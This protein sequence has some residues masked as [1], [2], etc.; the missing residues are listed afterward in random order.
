MANRFSVAANK[1]EK[2]NRFAQ[3]MQTG[4]VATNRFTGKKIASKPKERTTAYSSQDDIQVLKDIATSKGYKLKED[5]PSLF[6]RAMDIASRPLYA[7]AGAAKAL[8]KGE[9]VAQEAW[10]G[11]TGKEKETYS[12][13]L[14]SAGVKNKWIKGG[15]GLALDIAL[16]PTTYFGGKAI[17]LAA[18]GV[19]KVGGTGMRALE[20]VKPE[21]AVALT[22]GAKKLKEGVGGLFSVT[23]G[24]TEGVVKQ[25]FQQLNKLSLAKEE[26]INSYA[27][28]G[29]KLSPKQLEDMADTL[30]KHKRKL[31]EI[32]KGIEKTSIDDFNKQFP[33]KSPVKDISHAEKRFG[34]KD[35]FEKVFSEQAGKA[36][37]KYQKS[38]KMF[39]KKIE[40][41]KK[42]REVSLVKKQELLEFKAG[43]TIE[44]KTARLNERLESV[45]N[46][47]IKLFTGDLDDIKNS[48]KAQLIKD[49]GVKT[50]D[51]LPMPTDKEFDDIMN[52]VIN[53]IRDEL[54][55]DIQKLEQDVLGDIANMPG[56]K[57]EAGKQSKE[58]LA[59][60]LQGKIIKTQNEYNDLVF[61][62][63][64]KITEQINKMRE[65]L[66][67]RLS[68]RANE[69]TKKIVQKQNESF[70][71]QEIA[72]RMFGARD[73]AKS[74]LNKTKPEF[75]DPE[76]KRVY[77]SFLKPKIKEIG[78]K[79]GMPEETLLADYYP[80]ISRRRVAVKKDGT[81]AGVGVGNENYKKLDEGKMKIEEM[82]KDPIE[83]YT[84]RD[85]DVTR[86]EMNKVFLRQMVDDYGKKF[87]DPL[88]A[89]EEGYVM[90]KEKGQF[91]KELGYIK[92]NDAKFLNTITAPEYNAIDLFAKGVG[93]DKLTNTIKTALTAYFPA[94]HV[95]N[96]LSGLVQNYQVL[97][98]RAFAPA[99]IQTSLAILKGSEKT[100]L[101][102]PKWQGTAKELNRLFK[103]RFKGSSRYIGDIGD[104]I[105]ELGS[106]SFKMKKIS[107]ARAIGDFIESNQ[108]GMAISTALRK[109]H[110][111]DEAFDLAEKAG[112]DYNKM[113]G[114][115][116]SVMKRLIPFYAFA[117][118]NAKLQVG[119]MIHNPE[120]ILNQ[121]KVASALSNAIGEK[122]TEEDIKG[123]PDWALAGL[124]FKIKDGKY[125]SSLG[126][127]VEEFIGRLN[128]PIMSTLSSLN[129]M[130]K[131][132]LESKLGFDFFREQKIVDI[133]KV[134][135]ASGELLMKLKEEGKLPKIIDDAINIDRY[136]SPYDGK[137]K[138]TMSPKAL[139]ILRNIPT[140][141]LQN[142]LEKMFD[143]DLDKVNKFMAFFTGGK[144]Y[145]I[146]EETQAF[147]KERDLKTDMQAYL[148]DKGIGET[149]ENFYIKKEELAE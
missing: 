23:S 134:A 102:F 136:V 93:Y 121:V 19:N 4:T 17:T 16:D 33:S 132:P 54:E 114:F 12:D 29:T 106:N 40:N 8:V 141:R 68:L 112:F 104:Y 144:V 146:N 61:K 31:Q 46:D 18:K 22:E 2:A 72:N 28:L 140:A 118:N 145:D 81:G 47:E 99:N 42:K 87:D 36:I 103:E 37:D 58:A 94:F 96:M 49:V 65:S 85:F 128:N 14:E 66:A 43:E 73:S 101:K 79:T 53:P 78:K 67:E 77:E 122:V 90:L 147:F 142:T 109:G 38:I 97:G 83:A 113:T 26:I 15:V 110:T 20:K 75:S 21:S 10:K 7:S 111:L 25:G 130:V 119:T 126:L 127:P 148:Q 44:K 149:F 5:K 108:K 63:E 123:L 11:F 125:V 143:K 52:S 57:G 6:R 60:M 139:H 95:R 89:A 35:K 107:K 91:G 137:T 135:P 50:G 100:A 86:N 64:D 27:E 129:P 34:G 56:F 32:K 9:N 30:I 70:A 116:R 92:A 74:I 3:V 80:S 82:I 55:L 76:V 39:T 84:R 105:E 13:V 131:Y 62:I 1:S 138:Y 41:I 98:V 59:K 115:E 51:D 133:D 24:K 124:G 69:L 88:K 48:L 71:K 117:K 45:L 120:R